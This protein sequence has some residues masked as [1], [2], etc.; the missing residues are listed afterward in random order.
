MT[1]IA[2][3]LHGRAFRPIDLYSP[4]DCFFIGLEMG[5]IECPAGDKFFPIFFAAV[6]EETFAGPGSK[7]CCPV[8]MTVE[9]GELLHPC[10]MHF[11]A[12]MASQAVALFEA[13]LVRAVAVTFGAF[14]LF[15]KD[16]LCMVP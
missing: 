10:A 3:E 14:D 5:D 4:L 12:L 7:V 9:A 2:V 1:L 8:G 13:E 6:A 16:M 15:Y 11:L